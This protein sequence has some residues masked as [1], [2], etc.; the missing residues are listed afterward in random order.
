MKRLLWP[1]LFLPFFS[2]AESSSLTHEYHLKNGLKLIVREDH[3]APVVLSSIWYRVGGSYES[4]GLTGV[5]HMLEHMMFKGT[6]TYGPGVL[7]QRVTENGGQQNAMTSSDYTAYYQL[8]AKD[9]LPLSFQF[10]ADRMRHLTLQQGLYN[11]EHQVVMEERRMRVDDDP[12]S[13]LLERFEAAAYVNNPY[14]HPVIGWMTDIQNLTLADLK[15]WYQTWYAPNNATVV[16][17]GDVNPDAVYQR[18]LH[19]FGAIP[20]MILPKMKPRTEVQGLG[21]RRVTVAVPAQLPMLIMGYNVP[22]LVTAK[23]QWQPY[24]L[25]LL[26]GILSA[27][28]SARFQKNLVRGSE[29]AVSVSADYNPYS[30]HDT[31]LTLAGVPTVN[32]TVPQLEAALIAEIKRLKTT[33]VS[34]DE[35]QRVKA[36]LIANKVFEKDSMM[37]QMYDIGIPVSVGLSWKSTEHY[38]EEIARITPLQIQAVARTYL[39]GSSLTVGILKPKS[40]QVRRS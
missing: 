32:H 36:Q 21:T 9:K 2:F 35:L 38:N 33:L 24:A 8:W 12:Q 4:D 23:A 30:L 27:G 16:V 14:H 13:L 6:K 39:K 26:S 34:Q 25:D 19:A 37:Y 7:I 1:L 31:L 15:T 29:L 20:P 11:Q 18:A 22:S 10:E 5:S 17:V 28:A 40:M 3:R